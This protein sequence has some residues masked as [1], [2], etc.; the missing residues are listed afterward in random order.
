MS[1]LNRSARIRFRVMR[2]PTTSW[3]WNDTPVSPIERVFGLPTSWNSAASRT[4]APAGDFATTAM[5]WVSTSL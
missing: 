2:A 4:S 5:V 3:W 1:L